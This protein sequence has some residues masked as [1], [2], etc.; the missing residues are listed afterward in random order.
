[1]S[2]LNHLGHIRVSQ[3]SRATHID[4]FIGFQRRIQESSLDIHTLENHVK[5]SSDGKKLLLTNEAAVNAYLIVKKQIAEGQ[6]FRDVAP[7]FAKKIVL[8]SKMFLDAVLK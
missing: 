8:N 3:T 4:H 5:F 2:Q 1:M 6:S 7:D